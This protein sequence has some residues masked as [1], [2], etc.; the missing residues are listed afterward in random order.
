MITGIRHKGLLQLWENGKT[1]KLPAEL[2]LKIEMILEV[3][4]SAKNVPQDFESFKNWQ[5]HQ[6]KGD[7]QEFWSIKVNKNYRI[8]FIFDGQNAFELDYIDYH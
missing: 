1:N 6:L 7:L 2:I 8:V 5:L 3:I 4:D